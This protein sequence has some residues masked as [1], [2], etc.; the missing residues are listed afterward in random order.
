VIG[1][2]RLTKE[3]KAKIETGICQGHA[4]YREFNN[5]LG[6]TLLFKTL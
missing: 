3:I 4:E 5:I 2:T 6:N 1:E